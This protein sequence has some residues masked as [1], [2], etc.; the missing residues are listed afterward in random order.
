MSPSAGS[1][2]IPLGLGSLCDRGVGSVVEETCGY[3]LGG[4]VVCTVSYWVTGQE[5]GEVHGNL[6]ETDGVGHLSG[7]RTSAVC[8]LG[9][10]EA[11]GE[12][13]VAPLLLP[14]VSVTPNVCST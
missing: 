3:E 7:G 6:L 14:F 12:L 8:T 10:N 5:L 13:A 4:L 2:R 9:R 1:V 11:L